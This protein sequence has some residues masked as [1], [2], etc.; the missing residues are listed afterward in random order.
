MLVTDGYDWN[1]GLLL[2]N[3]LVK[4]CKLKN[5]TM[6]IRLPIG[7]G[8]LELL[9][10]ELHRKFE[11]QPYLE[12]MYKAIFLVCYYGLMRIGEVAESAHSVKA[13]DVHRGTNKDK[14]IILLY[15]SKTHSKGDRPQKIELTGK[16]GIDITDKDGLHSASFT[17]KERIFCPVAHTKAFIQ[18][19]G[20]WRS[21]DEQLFVFSDGSPLKATHVRST[22][23]NCI[24]NIGLEENLY[25][26]HSFRIGRASDLFKIEKASIDQ[27]KS[28]GRWKSNAVYKYLKS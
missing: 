28:L 9:M 16:T 4:S 19:R 8:L 2:L 13:V 22:L 23:R 10:F 5:D 7:K 21:R 6:K 20:G 18:M 15:S 14:L 11:N 27:I 17:D 12:L 24:K 3:S 26:T 1:G 25:D